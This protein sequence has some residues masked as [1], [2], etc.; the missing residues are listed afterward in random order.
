MNKLNYFIIFVLISAF[1]FFTGCTNSM[2]KKMNLEQ[3]GEINSEK[4]LEAQEKKI[5]KNSKLGP[6]T[7]NDTVP[8]SQT[9]IA[10]PSKPKSKMV[11]DFFANSSKKKVYMNFR[12]ADINAISQIFALTTKKNIIVGKEVDAQVRITLDNIPV[13]D[14]FESM[15]SSQGLYQVFSNKGNIVSLHTPEIALALE[16]SDSGIISRSS[17]QV[18]TDIFKIH[19]A[20]AQDLKKNLEEI[21]KSNN[22]ENSNS[23]LKITTDNRTKSLVVSADTKTMDMVSSFIKKLDKKT[24]VILIEAIIVLAKDNF[25]EAL[26]ARLGLTKNAN[27]LVSGLGG[28][29]TSS[30]TGEAALTTV[31][32]TASQLAVGDATGSLTNTLPSSVNAGV[33]LISGIGNMARLKLEIA[34]LESETL[35][36]T[37]SNPRIFT[38][39][40]EIAKISQGDQIPYTNTTSQDGATVSFVDAALSLEVT[41]SVVGDGNVILKVILNNDSADTSVSNPPISRTEISTNLLVKSGEIVVIGGTTTDSKSQ[42]NAKVPILGD[43]PLLGNLFKGVTNS[44]VMTELMIFISPVVL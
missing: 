44:D 4:I 27:I 10:E 2:K 34:A 1:L 15:L 6:T 37:L 7:T 13:K 26:G 39:D 8:F 32:G 14:A 23:S 5:A 28:T 25:A 30:A 20:D 24:N 12:N 38:M 21:F 29:S 40:N 42:T 3:S 36:R 11:D 22:Q 35:S 31:G 17:S 33:G 41:P 43:L 19:Y 18:V 16:Q 9:R